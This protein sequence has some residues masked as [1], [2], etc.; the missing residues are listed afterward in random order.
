[1]LKIIAIISTLITTNVFAEE[2]D[3]NN[4]GNAFYSGYYKNCG[5][6]KL[7]VEFH[8]CNQ[9][10]TLKSLNKYFREIDLSDSN[11]KKYISILEE[12]YYDL[13]T[14]LYEYEEKQITLSYLEDEINA[15]ADNTKAS[16]KSLASKTY[17]KKTVLEYLKYTD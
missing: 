12:N 6:P 14:K 5:A 3:L 10:Y 9:K 13:L 11:R 8:L 7:E 17:T 16:I 4:P 2:I 15:I 1:M